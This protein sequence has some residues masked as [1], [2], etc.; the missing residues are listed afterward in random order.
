[1]SLLERYKEAA[2]AL[3]DKVDGTQQGNIQ[4]AGLLIAD[5]VDGGGVIH[6]HN[7]CHS[8]ESDLLNRGGGPAFYR[9]F[10]YVLTVDNKTRERDRSGVDTSEEGIAGYALRRSGALPGDVIVVSSVS[11]RSLGAC[12]LAWE[13]KKFGMKVIAFVSM[14]YARAVEPTHSSGKKLYEIADVTLDNCAPA[15]EA[16]LDV[17]ELDAKF[18]AASGLASDYIMWCVTSVAVDALIARGKAP[19]VFKSV[20]FPGGWEQYRRMCDAYETRGY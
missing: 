2:H 11:G 7:I 9:R 16:M 8:I 4:A 17:P 19:A 15:A 14:E 18:A 20:N 12:D 13:A 10:S 5:S 3:L 6:L 1:M